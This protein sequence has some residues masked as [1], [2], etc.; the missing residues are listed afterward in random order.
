MR[1]FFIALIVFPLLSAC[2]GTNPVTGER[3]ITLMSPQQEIALGAQQYGPSVQSQGGAY[4][5]DKGLTKYL[6]G[7]G[8]RL[9]RHSAQP[10]LPY[11][12]VVINNDV[13]NAWA[14]P[15]GKIAFNTG[16]LYELED[17]AQLAAVVGHEIVHAAARHGAEQMATSQ[18]INLLALLTS[19]RTDNPLYRQAIGLT[20]AGATA[21]YGR[22]N[23]LEADFY[24]INYMV[25]EGYDPQGA[26]ELQQAFVRLAK[27]RGAKSDWF[28]NLFAS[29]PPSEQRVAANQKR[30]DQLPSGKRNRAAF[31]A[32]TKQ[33]KRDR[34]AYEKHRQALQAAGKKQ[35]RQALRLSNQAIKIQPREAQPREA[36]FHVTKGRILSEQKK[37]K[38]ALA[39]LNRAVILEP[40]YFQTR[41]YRGV[42]QH[43]LK[44]YDAAKQDF[45]ASNQLLPTQQAD[46]FLGEISLQKKQY[47]QALGYFQRVQQAGGQL[48]N[49]ASKRIAQLT[50]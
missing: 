4:Q 9:A 1:K 16:L 23:E 35:W 39:S 11:E 20:A 8:Q 43:N 38:S 33:L 49:V 17:E 10:N 25:S 48:G 15:G 22:D 14:L 26:V 34:P 5:V 46:Y 18:G 30:A 47:R 7:V 24:G 37:P 31:A 29:H 40:D 27:E 41:F 45:E 13:P 42:V 50:Q 32:A 19:T 36:R 2:I 28:S 21:R 3:Q 44:Y 12:F 6:N